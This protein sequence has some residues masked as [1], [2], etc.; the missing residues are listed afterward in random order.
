MHSGPLVAA[1]SL[2]MEAHLGPM[3]VSGSS[4]FSCLKPHFLPFPGKVSHARSC[5][6]HGSGVLKK[7]G[8][9]RV[10]TGHGADAL[11]GAFHISVHKEGLK[12]PKRKLQ[13]REKVCSWPADC[14]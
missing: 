13:G 8:G 6:S 3:E 2:T 12:M 1:G 5:Q 10:G 9:E 14:S 11:D 7:G 4:E